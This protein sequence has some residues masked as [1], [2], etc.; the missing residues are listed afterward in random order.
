MQ[1]KHEVEQGWKFAAEIMGV[2]VAAQ[3]GQEYVNVV[4]AAIEQLEK[5]INQ[6]QYRNLGVAQLQG[7]VFEEWSAGTF[8]VD[9]TAADSADRATVLHSTVKDSVDIQTNSGK[10]YSAN[11]IRLQ[12]KV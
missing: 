5:N 10:S 4:E 1:S 7:Y 6:H 11:L 8:N 9:A 12:S 2:D 3:M